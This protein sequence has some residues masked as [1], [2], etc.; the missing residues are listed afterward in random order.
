[1]AERVRALDY[2]AKRLA[3]EALGVEVYVGKPTRPCAFRSRRP[4]S[5]DRTECSNRERGWFPTPADHCPALDALNRAWSVMLAGQPNL[6][7][8]IST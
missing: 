1:M 8:A 3:L 2:R 5:Y 6:P 4:Y 7:D